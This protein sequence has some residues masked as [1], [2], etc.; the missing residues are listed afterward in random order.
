M[1]TEKLKKIKTCDLVKELSRR[2][3]VEKIQIEP[4]KKVDIKAEGP[5]VILKV[6]D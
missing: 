2:E 6:I 3:G 4:Y 5:I 1:R